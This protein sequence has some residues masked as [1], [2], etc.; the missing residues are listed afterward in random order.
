MKYIKLRKN[1]KHHWSG[2]LCSAWLQFSLNRERAWALTSTFILYT[3]LVLFATIYYVLYFHFY[4][5]EK[6]SMNFLFSSDRILSCMSFDITSNISGYRLIKSTLYNNDNWHKW[7]RLGSISPVSHLDI[8]PE[9][10][11]S[12][13]SATSIWVN[14]KLLRYPFSLFG[15]RLDT[16]HRV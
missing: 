14:P 16:I 2:D 13:I 8:F 10:E 12:R 3:M 5:K 1:K 9:C 4:L 6:C 15:T 11:R 7:M